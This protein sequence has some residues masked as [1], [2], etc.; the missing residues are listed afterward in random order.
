[1]K[2]ILL[3]MLFTSSAVLASTFIG[4]GGQTGDVEL[5]V[6]LKQ[7][8]AAVDRIETLKQEQPEKRYC[9]CPENYADHALCEII[10]KLNEDQLKYCD[11]FVVMQLQ[12]LA[13]ASQTTQFEW[14]QSTMVNQNKIGE[15]VVDA[16]AQKDKKLI[17]IDQVKFVDLTQSKRMFLLTHELFHMDTFDGK[18]L[19]DEDPIGP[20]KY[21]YGVRDLLNAAAAGITLTSIDETVFQD[22]TKY[23][24]QSRS[25]KR[26]WFSVMT[27]STSLQDSNKTRFDTEMSRG[28][29]FSYQ[30]QFPNLFNFGLTLHLQSQ[31]GDKS[32]F[33]STKIKQKQNITAVGATYRYFIFNTMD[34]FSHFW[35]T[36]VQFEVLTERLD[37]NFDMSDGYSNAQSSASSTNLAGRISVYFP[38]KHD[39]WI[40][41]GVHFSDHKVSFPEFDYNLTSNSPTF[42]LGVAYGL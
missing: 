23:L 36:F 38:M 21:Q 14:V 2:R 1:M 3:T 18:N 8:R 26:H 15:R 20:F 32:I 24:S 39:F 13:R 12:K 27:P 16:V 31:G 17:Y 37:A 30:Y 10:N 11:R 6:S 4:N 25:T 22:Y 29:R 7:V 34:P 40:N 9:V 28:S 19:D 41:T 42:F 33:T 5:A 35:N